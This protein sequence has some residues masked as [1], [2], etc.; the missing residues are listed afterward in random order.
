MKMPKEPAKS[1]KTSK[2]HGFSI[3]HLWALTALVGIFIFVNT[4]PI[5][6]HDFWWHIAAGRDLALSGRI[7]LNDAYSYTM[8]GAP[9]PAYQTYWLMEWMLYQVYHWGGAA[10]VILF[11]SVIVTAAYA[12]T[13][14]LARRLSGS[15]RIAA[16]AALFAAALGINDWNARPQTITFLLAPLFL[17][18]IHAYRRR[19]KPWLLLIF[20]AGMVLWVNVH[21]SFPLGLLLIALWGA[22]EAWETFVSWRLCSRE[23]RQQELRSLLA[24]AGVLSAAALACLLNPRGIGVVQYIA[25]MTTDPV[26]Q[27]LVTEWAAPTFDTL[28]GQLFLSGLLLSAAVLAL[29]PKRPTPSQLLTFLAFGALGLRTLRGSIWFGLTM[30]SILAEHVERISESVNRRKSESANRRENAQVPS[31]TPYSLL[32][33]PQS[34][35]QNTLNALLAG[36]LL[37]GAFASL[38]W[39]KALWPLPPE[40]AGLISAETPVAATD[41]LLRERPQGNLF[42]AMGFGSYLIWAAQP[43]YSVFVDPRIELYPADLWMDYLR[44]SAASPGWEE[45]L[46]GYDVQTLMLSP[47][48]QAGLLTAARES[49]Q[50]DEIYTAAVSIVLTRKD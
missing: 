6:P 31:P 34:K 16:F 27:T 20:P 50:W 14:R 35:I 36:L 23:Q 12:L 37:L 44:L 39:F 5:R 22:D 15:W 45:R 32:P 2:L 38:P 7:P 42:H 13:L 29:S 46:E 41:F 24:P 25:T 47:Q 4:H 1:S 49:G 18:A 11:Q 33:T 40:K 10:L 21:G 28:G 30:A 19:P 8:R 43:A 17:S 48:E 26:I 3:A 9:Y